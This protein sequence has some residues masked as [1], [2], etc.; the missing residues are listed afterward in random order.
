MIVMSF[1][2]ELGPPLLQNITHL[3]N[4]VY[5]FGNL[6]PSMELR[7][8]DCAFAA[9]TMNVIQRRVKINQFIKIATDF[10]Y[11]IGMRCNYA[12]RSLDERTERFYLLT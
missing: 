10:F 8:V 4:R 2:F 3:M 9:L 5:S 6:L 1:F 12:A 7:I 11:V